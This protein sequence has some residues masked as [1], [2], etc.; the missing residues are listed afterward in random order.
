M[1]TIRNFIQTA[2]CTTAVL[3]TFSSLAVASGEHVAMH[4]SYNHGLTAKM[5]SCNRLSNEST[6][7]SGRRVAVGFGETDPAGSIVLP[8]AVQSED[9]VAQVSG[10]AVGFAET[11]PAATAARNDA[12]V[13]Q[14]PKG[15]EHLAIRGHTH[16]GATVNAY[17]GVKMQANC[18]C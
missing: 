16:Q 2:V 9:L 18:N 17:E 14:Q 10:V 12:G 6:K 4:E 15:A 11:D 3:L 13:S 5:V 7:Y 1:N 8:G